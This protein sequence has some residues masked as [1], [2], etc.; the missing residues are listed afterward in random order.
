M[1]LVM[2]GSIILLGHLVTWSPCK[3]TVAGR[4]LAGNSKV[5]ETLGTHI[6]KSKEHHYR[7]RHVFFFVRP[8]K[9]LY[10]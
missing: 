6:G 10:H 2:G 3:S 9:V 7:M 4:I 1:M 8:K 5:Y